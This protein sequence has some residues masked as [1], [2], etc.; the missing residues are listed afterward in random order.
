MVPARRRPSCQFLGSQVPMPAQRLTPPC[1]AGTVPSRFCWRPCSGCHR[2]DF[3]RPPGRGLC[4][5][6]QRS[7]SRRLARPLPL[8]PCAGQVRG[9]SARR[10]LPI[11]QVSPCCPVGGFP[12]VSGGLLAPP[13]LD[14]GFACA[15]YF[16][17]FLWLYFTAFM[18][19]LV[20][21]TL[22]FTAFVV[23]YRVSHN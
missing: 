6:C 13:S 14:S 3:P 2:S 7:G 10:C 5:W 9:D 1:Q 4:P 21:F 17:D 11:C 8:P 15:F 16:V 12:G 23:N 19:N 22:C 18:V 20:V